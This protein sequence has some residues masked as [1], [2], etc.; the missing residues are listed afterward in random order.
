MDPSLGELNPQFCRSSFSTVVSFP[1]FKATFNPIAPAMMD[2]TLFLA[3]CVV[4][5]S[6]FYRPAPAKGSESKDRI[7]IH[8]PFPHSPSVYRDHDS[9]LLAHQLPASIPP[10][11]RFPVQRTSVQILFCAVRVLQ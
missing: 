1:F 4:P 8:S 7:D 9:Y 11:S 10:C 5:T 2:Y 3:Y 6:V